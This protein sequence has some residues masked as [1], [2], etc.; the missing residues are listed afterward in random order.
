M[1]LY[2][3]RRGADLNDRAPKPAHLVERAAERLLAVRRPGRFRG[4]FAGTRSRAQRHRRRHRATGAEAVPHWPVRRAADL[5]APDRR[6]GDVEEAGR[7]RPTSR[8]V[9]SSTRPPCSAP[10]CSTGRAGAAAS[11]RS[12]AWLSASCCAPRSRPTAEAGAVQ[13]A[14]GDQ[15]PAG[16]GQEL[17]RA[18]SRR[19]YRHAGRS[20]RAADRQRRQAGFA[21]PGTGSG[22]RAGRARPRRRPEPRP[23]RRDPA[24]PR[25]NTS[26]S[27]R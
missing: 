15:R 20:P 21:L 22:R 19:Q 9:R 18:Q 12:S 11:P 25:S 8:R 23:R 14:D 16:R 5:L 26:R 17:H 2:P 7:A 4:A 3:A 13:P 6:A 24:G 1:V 27:C 10:A